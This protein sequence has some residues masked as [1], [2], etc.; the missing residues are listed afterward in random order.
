ML[1]LKGDIEYYR[2]WQR[3]CFKFNDVP[4]GKLNINV[5]ICHLYIENR[6]HC[7]IIYQDLSSQLCLLFANLQQHKHVRVKLLIIDS[8]WCI[9]FYFLK[10]LLNILFYTGMNDQG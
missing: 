1:M 6:V 7:F 5:Y 8:L 2:L 9:S 3:S 4:N 10:I